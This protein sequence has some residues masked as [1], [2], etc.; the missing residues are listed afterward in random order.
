MLGGFPGFLAGFVAAL[1]GIDRLLD[2]MHG[3]AGSSVGE[4][5]RRFDRIARGRKRQSAPLEHLAEE[6]GWAAT[7]ERRHL[8]VVTIPVESIVGTVDP[9]KAVAFDADWRAPGYSR[10]RWAQMCHAVQAGGNVPPISVYRA[11]GRHYVRDGHHRV[12]VA[13]ALGTTDIDAE[14]VELR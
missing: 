8:G 14:V 4:A 10:T 7:A 1:L 9:H 6:T 11:R 13:R 5:E 2:R 3:F 12:S